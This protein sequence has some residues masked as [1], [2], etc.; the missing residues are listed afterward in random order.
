MFMSSCRYHLKDLVSGI[1][2]AA[3][4]GCNRWNLF[5]DRRWYSY[6]EGYW[7]R[8]CWCTGK[9]SDSGESAILLAG[10]YFDLRGGCSEDYT[11]NSSFEPPESARSGNGR[12]I[13]GEWLVLIVHQFIGARPTRVKQKGSVKPWEKPSFSEKTGFLLYDFLTWTTIYNYSRF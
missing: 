6:M 2:T 11:P 7:A 10:F 1:Y 13:P 4:Q 9:A 12:L 3:V 8:N 5:S